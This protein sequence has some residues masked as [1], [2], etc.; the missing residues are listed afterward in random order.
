MIPPVFGWDG[1]IAMDADKRNIDSGETISYNGYLYWEYPI[2]EELVHITVKEQKSGKI[3]LETSVVPETKAVSYFNNTA[4]PFSFIVDT[5]SFA[6]GMTYVVE[7]KYDD[8]STK[9][10]F[11][12]KTSE[13]MQEKPDQKTKPTPE[14]IKNQEPEIEEPQD[15]MQD[16][17]IKET[18]MQETQETNGGGCLIA[19]A[20]YGTELA[21]QVQ[22]LRELRDTTI[23]NSV[24]GSAF[25]TG[26]NQ[27]YYLFSPTIA[28]WERQNPLVKE[29]V[30][31]GITPMISSLS[32]LGL[33]EN[34]SE[35]QV[36]GA[37]ISV[38]LLN[39]GMYFG[40]PALLGIWIKRKLESKS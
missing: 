6:D 15:T 24:S 33:I 16:I 21:P 17:E 38:I 5:D 26:F 18:P 28:D 30:K 35:S 36:L 11:L 34:N 7:A 12:I 8:K 10:D 27:V 39:V 19:T 29:S 20:T 25:L 40:A 14:I 9:L 3:L 23:K 22:M 37:G 4:W 2:D 32:I 1:R 13:K 31:L